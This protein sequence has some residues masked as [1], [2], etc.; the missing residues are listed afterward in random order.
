MLWL[1]LPWQAC[2]SAT[3]FSMTSGSRSSPERLANPNVRGTLLPSRS[4][5]KQRSRKAQAERGCPHLVILSMISHDPSCL[6]HSCAPPIWSGIDLD[7]SLAPVWWF[8]A[9][10]D[11]VNWVSV[12][13]SEI[14][15]PRHWQ[16]QR[17]PSYL[18]LQ[19][20]FPQPEK[21]LR[22]DCRACKDGVLLDVGTGEVGLQSECV[23]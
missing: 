14:S 4:S 22:T 9:D 3:A 23:G 7:G 13:R 19:S 12:C 8:T 17:R 1:E 10:P 2:G 20:S 6:V 21:K 18:I 5:R 11:R 16:S 15:L